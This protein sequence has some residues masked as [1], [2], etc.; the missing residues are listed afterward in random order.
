MVVAY[1][2]LNAKPNYNRL[3][4]NYLPIGRVF[5]EIFC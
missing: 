3:S 5:V 4:Y 1:R 2:V